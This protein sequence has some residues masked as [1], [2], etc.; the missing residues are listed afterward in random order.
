[1]LW[2]ILFGLLW[3][4]PV[5][6][7]WYGWA[8]TLIFLALGV[9]WMFLFW[10]R[11]RA[12]WWITTMA[13]LYSFAFTIAQL[14]DSGPLHQTPRQAALDL[15]GEA[16]F[17]ALL[18]SP[19]VRRFFFWRHKARDLPP[20]RDVPREG[21][22]YEPSRAILT[23]NW[24]LLTFFAFVTFVIVR[25]F[26]QDIIT[27]TGPATPGKSGRWA[28]AGF[29]ILTVGIWLLLAAFV[30]RMT[31]ARLVAEESGLKVINY[32]RTYSLRWEEIRGFRVA[33]ASYWGISIDLRDGRTINANAVQKSN[34]MV[35]LNVPR[36]ADHVVAELNDGLWK[37]QGMPAPPPPPLLR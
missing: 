20:R 17:L 6:T 13:F 8:T 22:V 5:V 4:E 36:R 31:R 9:I 7:K 27:Q 16:A 11:V 14:F 2:L 1:V 24:A 18:L 37:R 28:T 23:M 32:L 26:I 3:A 21:K 29:A 34:L 10:R 30:S 33:G 19:S 12:I 15:T 25:Q 35:M